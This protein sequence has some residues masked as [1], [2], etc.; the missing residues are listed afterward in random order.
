[1][2]CRFLTEDDYITAQ[3]IKKLHKGEWAVIRITSGKKF[4]VTKLYKKNKEWCESSPCKLSNLS[5]LK[6]KESLAIKVAL[7]DKNRYTKVGIVNK[8]GVQIIL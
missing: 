8:Q 6:M 4:Y 5:V 2:E 1:M 3:N 7:A